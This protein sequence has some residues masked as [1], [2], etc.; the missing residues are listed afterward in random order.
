MRPALC[1]AARAILD[2]NQE[3]LAQAAELS[4]PT[5]AKFESGQTTPGHHNLRAIRRALETAGI[6]FLDEA[7]GSIGVLFK[8]PGDLG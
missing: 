1:R 8:Q 4:Q 5:I 2:W 7:D 6:T 3:K